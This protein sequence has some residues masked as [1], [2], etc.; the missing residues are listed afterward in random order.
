M[1]QGFLA[2]QVKAFVLQEQ[3]LE[4]L[5]RAPDG[6]FADAVGA[7]DVFLSA[8]FAPVHQDHEQAVFDT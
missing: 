6:C 4:L 3:G 5:D 8:V 7:A 1:A 2:R